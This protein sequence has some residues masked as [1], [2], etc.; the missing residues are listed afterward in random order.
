MVGDGAFAADRGGLSLGCRFEG[1]GFFAFHFGINNGRNAHLYAFV[2]ARRNGRGEVAAG[3]RGDG[4]P[5]LAAVGAGFDRGAG[6][7]TQRCRAAL[8]RQGDGGISLR[9]V[10]GDFVHQR[11][12]FFCRRGVD[13]LDL[14][15]VSRR[16]GA[17]VGDG[18][19]DRGLVAQ[20]RPLRFAQGE[21]VGFFV[22]GFLVIY[23]VQGKFCTGLS[24]LDGQRLGDFRRRAE[25]AVVGFVVLQGHFDGD[26][27][28]A[29]LAQRD[30]VG[31]DAAF[32]DGLAAADGHSRLAR[33]WRVRRG[34]VARA[35]L[36]FG[37]GAGF[38][39]TAVGRNHVA[40]V[41][42]STWRQGDF[43]GLRINVHALRQV[44]ALPLAG[45]RVFADGQRLRF[46]VLVDV[47]DGQFVRAHSRGDVNGA[48][49]CTFADGRCRRGIDVND[50]GINAG[51][52]A[53]CGTLR[54]AD[55]EVVVFRT[56]KFAV[57]GDIQREFR[58]GLARLDGERLGRIRRGG[59]VGIVRTLV[60]QGDGDGDVFVARLA[61]FDGVAGRLAFVDAFAT[62]DGY[63]RLARLRGRRRGAV[64]VARDFAGRGVRVVAVVRDCGYRAFV[65][66]GFRRQFDFAAVGIQFAVLR[67]AIRAPFARLRVFGHG[68]GVRLVA[69]IFVG[70]DDFVGIRL[71]LDADAAL[72]VARAFFQ[73]GFG[74]VVSRRRRNVVTVG[75]FFRRNA[76]FAAH[77]VLRGHD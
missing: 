63:S 26:V 45:C 53:Q 51:V 4:L 32:F 39:T 47:F 66:D 71:R 22:F 49:F 72:F 65:F 73:Q 60:G 20:F 43:A 52:F 5:G 16:R 36:A 21:A 77:A 35:R 12:A 55:G 57:F 34:V 58:F 11:L 46:V 44:I 40:V 41:L 38:A 31:R 18:R 54:V 14:C 74:G 75:D 17:F 15:V 19:C 56:F 8:Q 62:T 68:D 64:N 24:R 25:V 6:V 2:A 1:E 42:D 13:G 3:V 9:R 70:D 29:R 23:R 28:V 48:F 50:L 59:E 67:Q 33:L 37:F 10:N 76:A 69:L 61:Q 7:G 30:F 27:F